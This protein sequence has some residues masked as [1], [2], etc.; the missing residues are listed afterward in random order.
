MSDHNCSNCK[1]MKIENK[2]MKKKYKKHK[3]DILNLQK[4][5][6]ELKKILRYVSITD[7]NIVTIGSPHKSSG[8][9]VYGHMKNIP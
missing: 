2:N 9:R 8:L 5:M 4:E 3:K 7:G 6:A 1:K